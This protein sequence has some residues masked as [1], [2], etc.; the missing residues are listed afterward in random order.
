[1][2]ANAQREPKTE[3]ETTLGVVALAISLIRRHSAGE[4]PQLSAGARRMLAEFPWHNDLQALDDCIQRALVLCEGGVLEPG[5]LGMA[6]ADQ[7]CGERRATAAIL[8]SLR[9]THGA[10]REAARR[11]GIAPRTLRLK[12]A[13]LK[14]R[15]F[16]LP[17]IETP[18]QSL[19][20][21]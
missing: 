3:P 16:D 2:P 6:A 10:R 5:H 20:Y 9:A 4:P 8:K 7:V 18:S 12:L 15:G 13:T 17:A 11:L 14:Q 21:E 19:R 1:M